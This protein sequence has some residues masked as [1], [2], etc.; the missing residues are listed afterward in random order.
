MVLRCGY[1]ALGRW[2]AGAAIHTG[3]AGRTARLS[4]QSETGAGSC[5][6]SGACT[7]ARYHRPGH[8]LAGMGV[9]DITEL[10]AAAR[11]G[12]ARA[13]DAVFSAVYPALRTLAAARLRSGGD[14]P[15]L[16]PT[17]LVNEAYVKLVGA[18]DLDFSDQ[19]H[20]FACA[21]RAMRQILIDAYRARA[22]LKRGGAEPA[23]AL[24]WIDADGHEVTQSAL[25][26]MDA[27]L[28]RLEEINPALREL[29]E[30]RVFAG[31]TLDQVAQ[32]QQRS[33]RTVNREWQR[34]RALL[35]AQL[36]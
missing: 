4:S 26:D 16:S 11:S 30:L 6:P 34:A 25:L 3:A 27:A 20:F 28:D 35:L 33:L 23:G 31:L 18:H 15:T 2:R 21:A 8:R 17:A 24:T 19:H 22:S 14:L 7:R 1:E 29:V 32:A 36:A 10:L 9:G 13:V 12:E 5:Q